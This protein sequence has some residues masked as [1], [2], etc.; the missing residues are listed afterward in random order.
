MIHYCCLSVGILVQPP[1][2][3]TFLI[4]PL[5]IFV[6]DKLVSASRNKTE[7]SITKAELLPSGTMVYDYILTGAVQDMVLLILIGVFYRGNR[8]DVQKTS[9]F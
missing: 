5:V 4:G 2:L 8:F 1:L 3:Y 7:I 9:R 6:L